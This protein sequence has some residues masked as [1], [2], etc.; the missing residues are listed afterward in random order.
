MRISV[1][2]PVLAVVLTAVLAPGLA[3]AHEAVGVAGGL[4]SGFMH[5]ILGLDHLVAMVAVGLWGAQLGRPLIFAL[6]VAFPMM[7]AL[8]A[9]AGIAGLPLPDVELGI[10]LSALALGL[11]VALAYRAPVWLAVGIVGIFA[12]F[13]GYAHGTELPAAADPLAYGIGFVIATGLLHLAGILIGQLN[14]RRP[15]GAGLVRAGGGI[16]AC[17]GA[18]FT[19]TSLGAA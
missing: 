7:M 1:I 12:I 6:P 15:L 17:M 2:F 13:H 10:A 5:P 9:L 11:A 4:A 16:I 14:E 18:W 8:G 19:M 3:S